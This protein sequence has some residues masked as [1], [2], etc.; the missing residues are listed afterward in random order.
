VHQFATNFEAQ[1]D[2]RDEAANLRKFSG[3]FTGAF[4]SSLVR[5]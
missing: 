4:W 2:F 3:F 1:L 5:L